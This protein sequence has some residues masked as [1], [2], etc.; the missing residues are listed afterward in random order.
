MPKEIQ[1]ENRWGGPKSPINNRESRVV[2]NKF[3]WDNMKVRPNVLG[4]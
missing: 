2:K 3:N 4:L 1:P